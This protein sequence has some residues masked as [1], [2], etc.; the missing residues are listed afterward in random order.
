MREGC[1]ARTRTCA[2]AYVAVIAVFMAG[3]G[4][5]ATAVDPAQRVH[6]SAAGATL[7]EPFYDRAFYEYGKK[8][9][10]TVDYQGVGSGIGIMRFLARS[11]DFA[12]S[13]VPITG[14]DLASAGGRQE[15]VQ[16]PGT[17]GVVAV[18]YNAPT[19]SG[20]RLD[21]ETLADIF[22]GRIKVWNDPRLTRL[23]SG[24]VL[25]STPITVVHR[26]DSSGTS[27]QFTSYLSQV[28]EDWKTSVGAGKT[29]GWP[30]GLTG[31]GNEAVG[32]VI[33]ATPGAIGYVELAHAAATGMQSAL[34]KNRA[35][36]FV[37]ATVEGGAAAAAQAAS[38]PVPEAPLLL[39]EPGT[40]SY[41]LVAVTWILIHRKGDAPAKQAATIDLVRWLVTEG[42]QFG[43]PTHYAALPPAFRVWA[44]QQLNQT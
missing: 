5:H 19:V 8:H 25:P 15:V 28:S 38:P 11:V 42:Q 33:R 34:L 39:D 23:N 26:S 31:A 35:G 4:G 13:D 36:A 14:A 16:V 37:A 10:V 32:S 7:P 44:L 30:L 29:V 41:P 2:A 40:T 20:L 1:L 24:M 17:I 22:L 6:L 43:P 3:C 21:G 9:P 27:F 18:A 12:A